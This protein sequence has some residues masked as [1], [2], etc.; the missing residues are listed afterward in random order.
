MESV[1]KLP[2]RKVVVRYIKR[3]K[4]MASGSHIGEDHI[5]SG[6]ML[7]TATK[8]YSPKRLRNGAYANVLTAVEKEYLEKVTGLNLSVYSDYWENNLVLLRKQ[9]NE[10]YLNKPEDYIAVKILETNTD[11]VAIGWENRDKS[12]TYEFVIM[13]EGEE[14]RSDKKQFDVT[15]RAWKEYS[16]VEDDKEK[17]IGIIKLLE[18]KPIA[19]N[20]SLE[21]VQN[22]VEKLVSERPKDFVNL[23]TDKSFDTRL[24]ITKGLDTG[25]LVREN[26][27][28]YTADGIELWDNGQNSSFANTVLFLDD[29]KHQDI[30]SLI[31]AKLH[32]TKE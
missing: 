26:S 3:K 6:G 5:I 27:K 4:G 13:E 15:K 2:E 7:E 17:L 24:L 8:R 19:N 18:N 29:V 12:L 21:W 30:R 28:Y 31:E 9:D 14:M 16:K 22:K 23:I 11:R 25:I 1:F 10:F 20:S 32:N